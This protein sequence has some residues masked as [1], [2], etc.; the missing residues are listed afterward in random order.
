[1]QGRNREYNF[2][3]GQKSR[4]TKI[5]E[6]LEGV[7][8]ILLNSIWICIII[9]I[10]AAV[11]RYVVMKQD[12]KEPLEPVVR[13][14]PVEAPVA[15][16]AVDQAVVAALADARKSAEEFGGDR[17]D[18]WLGELMGRVDTDFLDWYFS[19]WT[20]QV[21]G[22]KALGQMG[23][24]YFF[25][26]QP[27]AAEALTRDIQEEFTK[28]VLRPQ[29]AELELE[30]IVRE[31]VSHYVACL[32]S[33]L[34]VIPSKYFIPS[35]DWDRYIDGMVLTASNT[36]ADREVPLT[37]KTV[38]TAGSGGAV[39]LTAK[40]N[41]LVGKLSG[42]VMA[43]SA[44]KAASQMAVKT[45]GKVAAKAGGKFF[46]IIVGV[47]V[48]AWDVWDHTAT[49]KENWPILRQ[50][51]AGYFHSLKDILLNDPEEG[52][53]AAFDDLEK[54]VAASLQAR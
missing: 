52:M 28:R 54:Q 8:K 34:E 22:L 42:K 35:A 26:T 39:L 27:T 31:T 53:T 49:K 43:K 18:A 44:G 23:V 29:L 32:R 24:H 13:E 14:K 30:R 15:W 19:Y 41:A 1:M 12:I 2:R 4:L 47:G 9:L 45:G 25:E 3:M 36:D 6:R 51:L 5:A 21:F 11:G 20:Q 16:D 38:V 40:M 37:L 46:G 10:L 33:N 17:L 7:R 48:I 50:S